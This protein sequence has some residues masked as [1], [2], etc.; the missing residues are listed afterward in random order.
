[1]RQTDFL[2]LPATVQDEVQVRTFLKDAWDPLPPK[3]ALDFI[4]LAQQ[5]APL[6]VSCVRQQS[7]RFAGPEVCLWPGWS[8]PA[9]ATGPSEAAAKRAAAR[10]S[11][12][13]FIVL[14]AV[15]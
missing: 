4:L 3:A 13:V 15:G 12:L 7:A 14:I 10:L 6:Q 8:W 1:M 9:R 2:S 11:I 5:A